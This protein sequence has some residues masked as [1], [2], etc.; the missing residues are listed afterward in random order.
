MTVRRFLGPAVAV[1]VLI[2]AVAAY[3]VIHDPGTPK[4]AGHP[5]LKTPPPGTT[6]P[7][8]S[9]PSSRTGAG[10]GSYAALVLRERP[11]AFWRLDDASGGTA[12]DSTGRYPGTY[13]GRPSGDQPLSGSLGTATNFDGVDDHVT[14]N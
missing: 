11:L 6:T 10:S 8:N 14:A 2:A 1:I 13:V 9:T 3:A 12:R 4:R 7:S 5:G